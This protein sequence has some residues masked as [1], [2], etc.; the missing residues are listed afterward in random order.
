[1]AYA[2]NDPIWSYGTS[3]LLISVGETVTPEWGYGMSEVRHAYQDE[4]EP[5]PVTG[6]TML[7]WMQLRE[8]PWTTDAP[9]RVD[10]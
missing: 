9:W 10:W 6:G 1:M 3:K 2:V 7:Q 8:Y 4:P 5:E